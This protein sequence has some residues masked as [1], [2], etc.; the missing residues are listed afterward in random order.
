MSYLYMHRYV[1]VVVVS[2]LPSV[3]HSIIYSTTPLPA[4]VFTAVHEWRINTYDTAEC[5]PSHKQ[6]RIKWG[7]LKLIIVGV[8]VCTYIPRTLYKYITKLI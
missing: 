7:K 8:G 2:G 3:H 4:A 5:D 6:R 1:C